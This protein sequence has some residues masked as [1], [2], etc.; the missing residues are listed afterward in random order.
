MNDVV[1]E[2]FQSRSRIRLIDNPFVFPGRKQK[3]CRKD[4]P[5][6]WEEL[7]KQATIENFH[8]H[9]LRHT[10][11][12]RLVMAGVHLY[13]VCKLLGHADIKMTMR[14]SHLSPGYLKAA[15]DVLNRKATSTRTG[16]ASE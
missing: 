8:W 15:V 7:L 11:A 5:Y 3:E 9:D 2:I 13:T 16:T 4:L 1:F 10:F 6:Y 12:S 14:Y